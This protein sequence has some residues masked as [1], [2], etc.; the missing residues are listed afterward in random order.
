[1]HTHLPPLGLRWTIGNVSERGFESLGLSL[2]GA[3][4]LFG[5]GADYVVCVNGVSADEARVLTGPVP[6]GVT[7]RDTARRDLPAFLDRA[8]GS[9]MAEGVAWKLAPLRLFPDRHEI[10]LDNDCILWAL[11]PTLAAWLEGASRTGA[12]LMAEDV[13]ACHGRFAALCPS[14]PVNSG[15]RGLPPGFDIAAALRDAIA[16][17]ER[18]ASVT[19]TFLCEGDEQGL[20]AA[21]LSLA[22]PLHLVRLQEVT[23]CSP[24]HPHLPHLGPCGAHFV[25]LN[26]RHLPWNYYD[27]PADDWM[28]EHWERHRAELHRRTGAPEFSDPAADSAAS[29]PCPPSGSSPLPSRHP[30]AAPPAPSA[31]TAPA[32]ARIPSA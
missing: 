30:P 6:A 29:R 28:R 16:A 9:G 14:R 17:C 15:I 12:C 19:Q 8:F 10:A 27:R 21:A 25:G 20:Q 22:T 13:R 3:W 5:R 32:S 1:M 31:R 2:W 4:H 18:N 11:P 24:F 23:I 7:W 26:V